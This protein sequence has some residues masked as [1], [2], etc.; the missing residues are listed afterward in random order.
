MALTA[1]VTRRRLPV[2]EATRSDELQQLTEA[3]GRASQAFGEVDQAF[4]RST[5]GQEALDREALW[6]RAAEFRK[7][8]DEVRSHA[9]AVHHEERLRS[10]RSSAAIQQ[11]LDHEPAQRTAR[12][13]ESAGG[14][15]EVARDLGAARARAVDR[16]QAAQHAF[17]ELRDAHQAGQPGDLEGWRQRVADFRTAMDEVHRLTDALWHGSR[18]GG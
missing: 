6:R 5:V 3:V 11:L 7:I 8:V 14:S 13:P 2:I 17:L 4:Q 16:F 9:A 1:T 10:E 15:S 18:P 12:I